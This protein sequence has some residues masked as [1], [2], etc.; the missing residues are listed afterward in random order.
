MRRFLLRD[1]TRSAPGT[2]R[3]KRG[4][5]AETNNRR[6]RSECGREGVRVADDGLDRLRVRFV[7]WRRW[8]LGWLDCD[9]VGFG[10]WQWGQQSHR[11]D[12]RRRHDW[13]Y[14]DVADGN[15]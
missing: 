6:I 8:R 10:R 2:V 5:Y 13:W 7:R 12:K 4:D 14:R 15:G 1:S 9:V 11:R 3:K